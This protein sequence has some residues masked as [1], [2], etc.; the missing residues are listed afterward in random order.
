MKSIITGVLLGF[1]GILLACTDRGS[2]ATQGISVTATGRS[3]SW[4]SPE[5]RSI[6]TEWEALAHSFSPKST[7][8][9]VGEDNRRLDG[10]LEKRLSKEDLFALAAS[11]DQL[12][13]A[14]KD[15]T[16]FANAVLAHMILAFGRSG[17]REH[18][19]TLL[20]IRC[21]DRAGPYTD[22]ECFLAGCEHMKTLKYPILILGD[23]YSQCKVPEVRRV[24]AHAVRR[25]FATMK[26]SGLA[27]P[28]QNDDE[29]VSN[30]MKWYEMHKDELAPN[31]EYCQNSNQDWIN[32]Q[33]GIPLF[34]WKAAR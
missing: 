13:I 10:I 15:R 16:G 30:A 2:P 18:L 21:P 17:D 31:L 22:I 33:Y 25:G 14:A 1:V 11:C 4:N 32:G 6:Q 7:K 27:G 23:A 29:C 9:T 19:V 34:V 5:M 20:S 12:P 28:E 3:L 24:I 8:A 26:V